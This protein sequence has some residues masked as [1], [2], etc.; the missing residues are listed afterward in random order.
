MRVGRAG[1]FALH[2]TVLYE[3]AVGGHNDIIMIAFAVWAFAVAD[4]L[5]LV[6]GLLMGASI[7]VKYLSIVALPFLAV[8]AGRARAR[9]GIAAGLI[10][11]VAA[12]LFLKPFWTGPQMLY[13]L[14]GHGGQFGM[15]IGWLLNYWSFDTGT[16]N[17]P[18]FPSAPALPFFGQPSW[19][20]IVALGLFG[21]FFLVAAWSLWRYA[22]TS[23]WSNLWRTIA[24]FLW[25]SPIIHPW[26]MLWLSPA[27]AAGKRWGVYAWWFSILCFLPY[28]L[29]ATA[30][31]EVPLALMFA[32]PVIFLI[33]PVAI[34]MLAR[35][36]AQRTGDSVSYSEP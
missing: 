4:E 30:P 9:N 31:R 17:R 25:A 24:A 23:A 26:Y 36:T 13:T 8:Y 2:P 1:A 18:A 12:G 3:T 28:M 35:R 19:P 32:A 29:D 21:A 6:A 5:P 20:R 10:A 14:I 11:L 27:L 16:E 33:T 22:R 34:S 15:S 7:A